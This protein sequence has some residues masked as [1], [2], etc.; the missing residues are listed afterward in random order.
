M[1]N[2][3]SGISSSTHRAYTALVEGVREIYPEAVTA[4]GLFVAGSDS[5]HFLD[6]AQQIYRFNPIRLHIGPP[7]GAS[8]A[9]RRR[10]SERDGGGYNVAMFHGFNERIS[11]DG[12]ARLIH[13]YRALH[14]RLQK[15]G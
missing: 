14:V 7:E 4:P 6:L 2:E 3:P 11:V 5:K 1:S 9:E 13:F 15:H 10:V 8:E 12:Y